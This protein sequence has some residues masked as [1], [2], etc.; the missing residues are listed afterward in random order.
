MYFRMQY[1]MKLLCKIKLV[2]CAIQ[3]TWQFA[4]ISHFVKTKSRDGS[5]VNGNNIV[6]KHAVCTHFVL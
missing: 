5:K 2:L 6:N 1:S 4:I 3:N